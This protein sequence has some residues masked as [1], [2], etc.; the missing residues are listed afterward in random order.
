MLKHR[1]RERERDRD[2][3]GLARRE[4]RDEHRPGRDQDGRNGA[5]G[6]GSSS[7]LPGPKAVVRAKAHLAELIGAASE[8]VSSLTRT[9]DGWRVVLEI[10]EMQRVPRTTDIMASYA[11][12]LDGRGELIGYQRVARYYRSDVS[13][14]R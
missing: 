9:R 2:A 3:S 1:D 5:G 12:D 11:V 6:N 4:G 13:G 7:R 10:V 8:G 14:E